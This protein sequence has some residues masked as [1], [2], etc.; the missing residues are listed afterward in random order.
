MRLWLA[1]ILAT[2]VV[3]Q[4]RVA[5]MKRLAPSAFPDL[6]NAVRGEL[7]RRGCTIPQANGRQP[8][9]VVRGEFAKSGQRDWALFCSTNEAGGYTTRLLVFW[10][11]T[12]QSPAE[13]ESF[14]DGEYL[15]WNVDAPS[16]VFL[17]RSLSVATRDFI[18]EHDRYYGQAKGVTLPSPLDHQGINDGF[19]ESGSIVHYL[20]KGKWL[21]LSGA[22]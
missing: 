10:N 1:I 11:G 19:Y 21:Q 18:L 12:A 20:D 22:D 14:P 9:N 15:S 13:F 6:P 16:Q 2:V 17:S 5:Q 8:N 4:E 3:G 7:E